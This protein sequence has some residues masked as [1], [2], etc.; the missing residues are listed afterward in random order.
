[1]T[2][3]G[4]TRLI[5]IAGYPTGHIK[6][7]AEYEAAL[8]ARGANALYLSMQVS[9]AN[10][11]ACLDGLRHVENLAGLVLTIPHKVSAFQAATSRDET[12]E[13]AGSANLLRPTRTGWQATNVDGPGF[14]NAA[15][16]AGMGIAGQT[17]QLLG[18]GGAGR[19]VAMAIAAERPTALAVHDAEPA[20]AEALVA[21]LRSTFPQLASSIGLAP[22]TFLVNCTPAGMG[23]DSSLPCDVALIPANG[24]V[25]DI[26]NRADTPLLVAARARGC[27]TEHG[28]AMMMAE[29]PLIL[30]WLLGA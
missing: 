4:Y 9:P 2:P 8:A 20:R 23:H 22:S 3:N 1:M 29:V 27:R 13:R 15:R 10:F 12:V 17:V 5:V 18:A 16:S 24:T 6:G 19:A 7:F 28:Y 26:V 14:I 11:R 21:D 25:F 30:D